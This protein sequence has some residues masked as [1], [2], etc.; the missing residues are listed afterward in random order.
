M[1]AN[2]VTPGRSS[3]RRSARPP[4]FRIT[5]AVVLLA[6]AAMPSAASEDSPVGSSAVM[7]FQ[8]PDQ[9]DP[10]IR[11]VQERLYQV[12]QKQA[13]HLLGTVRPW[14]DD[15]KL[16]LLT[17]S[18]SL[19]HW[20]R[21]NGSALQGF[22]FLYRFGPY[23]DKIVGV[24]RAELLADTIVPMMR[25]LVA[26]HVTGERPTGDGKRWGNHW[27][28]AYWAQL[29]GRAAWWSWAD[30]PED[31]RAGVR[32]V[33]AHEAG[34]FVDQTPPHQLERDT[35]SEENAWNSMIFNVAILLMPA[36]PQRAAWERAL[37]RWV[38]SAY[39]RPA[40]EHSD[41]LVD[42]RPVSAQFTG[43]NIYDDFTLE[44][45]DKVHPDYMGAFTLSVTCRLDH[46]MTGRQPPEATLHN[47]PGIYENLKWF[48]LP[49]G[50]CVY[51][52]GED[53]E[54][55]V[56]IPGWSDLH[57]EMA[58]YARDPDAWSLL[59]KCLDTTE[60]M[61]ARHADGA[62]H[63]REEY[64]YPGAQHDTMQELAREWLMLQCA[65]SIENQPRPP[66]GVKQLDFGKVLIHRTPKAVHTLSWGPV[67]MAQ[68]VPLRTDRVISPHDRSGLGTVRL[69]GQRRALPLKLESAEISSMRDGFIGALVVRHGDAVRAALTVRSR[70]DGTLVV[71]ETLTALGDTTT[72]EVATGLV[73]VLN[74]PK[75]VYER[76]ERRIQMDEQVETIPALSGKT[77]DGPAAHRIDIDGALEI[78]SSKPLQARYWGTKKIER[79]RATDEL[80]LNYLGEPSE[81]KA[82][83]VIS[84]YEA[85]IAPRDDE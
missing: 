69:Q 4:V 13:H 22:S 81:W 63:A 16:K 58:V 43:A 66:S 30:L 53:W 76:H 10:S 56:N 11:R 85:T 12:A 46:V 42:G 67:I 62:I 29:L 15:A 2:R 35:K 52:N 45:H 7:P 9:A 17:D 68:C 6:A 79:G 54:L 34:R 25:Y 60:K 26:T 57:V 33:V 41:K 74:N 20:I 49:D 38:M 39:L 31:V 14:S 8:I 18:K 24:G 40:D 51:P 50:G 84:T 75:W 83:Q 32:R 70:P 5:A 23:D 27:Q 61:Q 55:F 48:F 64:F 21:P 73:G 82:G 3:F 37:Q 47:V 65:G 28:S 71:R 80:Y 72:A 36:D 1:N 19:E 77:L 59:Q 78:R 44:N